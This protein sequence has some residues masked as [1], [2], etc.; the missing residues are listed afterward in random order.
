MPAEG[1]VADRLCLILAGGDPALLPD[2]LPERP[3]LVIAA[4]SGLHLARPLGVTVDLV[5][6]DL[7]SADP[8]AVDEARRAG[9]SVERHPIGKDA[10]DLELALEAAVERG[11]TR[12]IVVG[13]TALERV[14]HL[15]ANAAL[16]AAPRFAGLTPEWWLGSTRVMV[17]AGDRHFT[18]A[19]GEV[20][21]I[22]PVGGDVQVTTTGLRWPLA[23]ERLPQGTTRGVSNEMSGSMASV[24]V[25]AGTALVVHTRRST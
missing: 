18:G 6:G 14:D 17:A 10:T 3:G 5:V 19:P 15:L 4:D 9:A 2:R 16:I 21:S 24:T 1:D 25:T 12:V 13:G 20:V 22:I 7:D 23:N 11:A 8:D